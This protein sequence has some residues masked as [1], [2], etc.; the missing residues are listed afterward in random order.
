MNERGSEQNATDERTCLTRRSLSRNLLERKN[1]ALTFYY[2]T[3][4][5]LDHPEIRTAAE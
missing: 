2:R 4:Q 5:A 3:Y 1:E